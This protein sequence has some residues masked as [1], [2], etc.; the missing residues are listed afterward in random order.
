MLETAVGYRLAVV[1]E[2]WERIIFYIAGNSK[3][4]SP[5]VDDASTAD[6]VPFFVII[7]TA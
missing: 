2:V 6:A 3:I 7:D 1:G 4:G 5:C